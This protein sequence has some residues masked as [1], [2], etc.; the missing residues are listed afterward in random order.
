[1]AQV[2]NKSQTISEKLTHKNNSGCEWGSWLVNWQEEEIRG[3]L[4]CAAFMKKTVV[5][6]KIAVSGETEV[7]HCQA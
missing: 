3:V 4:I 5:N 7:T 2:V 6:E 1:M